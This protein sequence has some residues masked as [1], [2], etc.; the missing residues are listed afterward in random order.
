MLARLA[1]TRN[2]ETVKNFD[3]Y[4]YMKV[5]KKETYHHD[6]SNFLLVLLPICASLVNPML[7]TQN[8]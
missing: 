2:A 4:Y 7:K 8:K 5:L 6:P 3:N 1:I